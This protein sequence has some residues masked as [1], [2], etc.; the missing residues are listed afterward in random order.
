MDGIALSWILRIQELQAQRTRQHEAQAL[1]GQ[2]L[3]D[4]VRILNLSLLYATS[5]K[6]LLYLLVRISEQSKLD[7]VITK[8]QRIAAKM[9][10]EQK[11]SQEF[12]KLMKGLQ[13]DKEQSLADLQL[14][15]SEQK[16]QTELVRQKAASLRQ[17]LNES[18]V[19][20]STLQASLAGYNQRVEYLH[21]KSK[22]LDSHI[23]LLK[24]S[25]ANEAGRLQ[26]ETSA[27]EK[28]LNQAMIEERQGEHRLHQEQ[29]IS[30]ALRNRQQQLRSQLEKV[31]QAV[32]VLSA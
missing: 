23:Q 28:L 26:E 30:K 29:A 27:K 8:K 25:H 11:E 13:M 20:E 16:R 17:S 19:E 10:Q 4:Q 7:Q 31:K 6:I 21:S 22:Q 32:L 15:L 24:Q 1:L 2:T 18:Q 14:K 12:S 3:Q 5:G 9:K